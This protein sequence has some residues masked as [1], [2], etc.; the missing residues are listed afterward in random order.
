MQFNEARFLCALCFG[1]AFLPLDATVI[2]QG[3]TNASKFS[4]ILCNCVD[5]VSTVL[6]TSAYSPKIQL[7]T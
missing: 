3:G 1:A 5:Q 6:D 4:H 2:L 7:E